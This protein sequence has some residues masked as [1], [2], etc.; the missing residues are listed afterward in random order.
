VDGKLAMSQQCALAAQKAKCILG[1]CRSV[2]TRA[3]EVILSLCSDETSPGVLH[4]DVQS[5]VQERHGPVGTCP[6]EGH[7]NDLR[8]GSPSLQGQAEAV[9]H[10]EGSEETR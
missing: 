9:H 1:C 10:G 8:D 2:V 6:E 3:R 4:I 7:K 5:S